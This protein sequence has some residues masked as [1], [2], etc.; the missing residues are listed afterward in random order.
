MIIPKRLY[1]Y[2]IISTLPVIFL[3]QAIAQDLPDN[4]SISGA[5]EGI[6]AMPSGVSRAFRN[7]NRY[8]KITTQNGKAIHIIAQSRISTGQ[9]VRAREILRMFLTDVPGSRYGSDKASTGNRMAAN[10]A[11]LMLVNGTH[12]EGNEPDLP[13]QPLY[14]NEMQVEGHPWYSSQDYDHRDASFEEILH[15]V[16]DTGIGVDGPNAMPGTLPAYQ[17]EIRKA[18]NNA[19]SKNFHIWP[20]SARRDREWYRDLSSENSLT[21]EYLASLIDSYYGL[22]GAWTESASLGMWG[23]YI[24][25]TRTEITTEDPM[26]WA[27]LDKFFPEYLT[28]EARIDPGFRGTFS[29]SFDPSIAYTHHSQFLLKA[30]LT[31]T[32]NSNLIGNARANTLTGNKGNNVLDGAAGDDTAVFAGA[33]ADYTV[34]DD[35]DGRINIV[36]GTAGRDGADTLRGIDHVSFSDGTVPVSE[37]LNRKISRLNAWRDEYFPTDLNDPGLEKTVWGNL[38][39]PD[40]DGANNLIEFAF[41]TNPRESGSTEPVS[42]IRFE[43][44]TVRL[45]LSRVIIDPNIALVTQISADLKVWND[46]TGTIYKDTEDDD[47]RHTIE[48]GYPIPDN[49]SARFLR[50]V[51]RQD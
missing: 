51:I 11:M 17:A 13:A 37:L 36:D 7:F 5:P 45:T 15:L 27:L 49:S 6:V 39:D 29:M 50:F 48:L 21:Q 4:I 25:K 12:S 34:T 42:S 31:G 33:R 8:T 16:H 1:S 23:E 10:D 43:G 22:W 18:T 44:T 30:R 24:S 35:G 26:G 28:Y 40:N 32:I 2:L 20:L 38:A 47:S 3:A 19:I 14:Q 41:G 9:I 46:V